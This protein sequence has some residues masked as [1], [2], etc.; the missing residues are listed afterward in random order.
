VLAFR[1]ISPVRPT[2]ILVIP[3]GR[4]V[5][6]DDFSANASDAEMAAFVRAIGHVARED[7]VA[8][9]GYRILAISVS[10]G[11]R[12]SRISCPCDRRR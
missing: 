3:K 5:S 7:G 1:D 6:M 2:H 9:D 8:A 12:K 4:Y 10:M 11:V